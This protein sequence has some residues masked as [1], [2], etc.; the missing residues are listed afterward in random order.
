MARHFAQTG[1]PAQG[2]DSA[3]AARRGWCVA[4]VVWL[5]VIWGHSLLAGP[6]SSA[7]SGLVVGLLRPVFAAVGVTDPDLMSLAVRKTAHFTEYLVLGVIVA[8]NC[9]VRQIRGWRACLLTAACV[10]VP[11]I[12]ELGIQARVPGRSGNMTDV[13]IDSA[14]FTVGT[15]L[16]WLRIHRKSCN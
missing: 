9:R 13:G 11:L 5:C 16:A 1:R 7:E 2:S 10:A 3:R 12:D 8:N 6:E 15:L 14:G 4:L